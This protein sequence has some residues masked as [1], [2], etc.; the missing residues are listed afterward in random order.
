MIMSMVETHRR[1]PERCMTL[2][3]SCAWAKDKAESLRE[4][5]S[6][7][8]GN[9]S[10]HRTTLRMHERTRSDPTAAD[11]VVEPESPELAAHQTEVTKQP[12]AS[13]SFLRRLLRRG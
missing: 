12:V 4:Q 10:D 11:A 1:R 6:I 5:V 13:A 9:V 8:Q 3:R 7:L 2:S